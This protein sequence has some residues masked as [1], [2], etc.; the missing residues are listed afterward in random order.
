MAYRTI[1]LPFLVKRDIASKIIFTA[2]M[3]RSAVICGFERIRYLNYYPSRREIEARCYGL[4]KLFTG[5]SYYANAVC[6]D[7]Y[8]IVQSCKELNVK[9]TDVKLKNWLY[10]ES[11]G[12]NRHGNT[13]IKLVSLDK[14]K[15]KLLVRY[16]EVKDYVI[17]VTSPKSKRF[18]YMLMELLGL[19]NRGQISYNARVYIN[20]HAPNVVKG[21]I[22]VSVPEEL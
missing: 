14:V 5:Y 10:F 4:A 12:D 13:G 16:S 3:Y 20:D 9:L 15:V 17:D 18:R 2:R 1:N 21:V 6:R 7:I 11:K 19:A 8:E 22:Q